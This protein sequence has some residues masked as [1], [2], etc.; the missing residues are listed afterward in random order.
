MSSYRKFEPNYDKVEGQRL[1]EQEKFPELFE[2]LRKVNAQRYR[3][4]LASL[5]TLRD[6]TPVYR[7][8]LEILGAIAPLHVVTTN[9]DE[10]LE[11]HLPSV[12]TIQRSDL[13]RTLDLLPAKQPFVAKLHGSVS[14]IESVVF[15]SADYQALVDSGTQVETLRALFAQATV[16][17]I[18]YSLRDEYILDLF[19]A[20]C[21]ARPLF[22][23]GPHFLITTGDT[24]ALPD[25]IRAIRYSAEDYADHR[26][27]ITVLDVVRVTVETGPGWFMPE[28]RVPQM[29]EPFGSA[30][31]L[32]DVTPPGTW[33]SSQSLVLAPGG[34]RPDAPNAIVG[35]G[36]DNSELPQRISPAMHDMIVGL[37]SFDYVH[38]PL[39]YAGRLHDLLGSATFW[40]L[41]GSGVFRFIYFQQEPTIILRS[42]EAVN[43]GDI[44]LLHL[45]NNDGQPYTPDEQ[46]KRQIKPAP[47]REAEAER[48]FDTLA[49][50]VLTF[51]HPRFNIPN[52]TRGALLH[53]SVQRLLGLSDAVVPTSIPRWLAFPVIRLAHTIMTGC[54][55]E[56]FRLP[57]TKIGF[58]SEVLVGAAFAVS[59][60]RD[61]ADNVTSYVVSG[62][63]NSDLGAYVNSNPSVWGAVLAFRETQAGIN[64]RREVLQELATNSGAEFIASVNAGLRNIVPS[65]IM[66]RA[67]DQV[68]ELMLRR[69]QQSTV[70]PAVWANVRNSDSITRLWRARSK[71]ELDAYCRK[72]GIRP[73]DPC[74]CGSGEKLRDCCG[75][76]LSR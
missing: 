11:R 10:M 24:R 49:R 30:Y 56:N 43:H 9:V 53:P 33:T 40:Q 15:A 1:F 19:A 48:L 27:A 51:E 13:E 2:A 29:N 31:F 42:A 47:G 21:G 45:S 3:R 4:E 41:V 35:Q 70:V 28:T 54:A 58:G 66:E 20:N 7:R 8:F 61:W 14:S 22:G 44:G 37:T 72:M 16:L 17:F 38:I 25:S 57:A 63:F 6:P 74:P 76:A 18:G 55:C 46:I 26:S 32:T 67:R 73:K 23:D 39:S 50:H 68:T 34:G 5:F 75:R 71:R 60:C 59:A 52:L 65:D 12:A 36:F 69:N 64:L 62:R